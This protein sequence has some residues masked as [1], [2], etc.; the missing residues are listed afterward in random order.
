MSSVVLLFN[1][2][3]C[4]LVVDCGQPER[5]NNGDRQ[6]FSTTFESKAQY[7]CG[8]GYRLEG[9]SERTCQAN[10]QW[11]GSVP[12]CVLIDCGN[13]GDPDNG[14]VVL[15][16]GVTTL[17]AIAQYECSTGYQLS[18]NVRRSCQS[19][20]TWSLSEPACSCECCVLCVVL[21]VVCCVLFVVC[22]A[23]A[24]HTQCTEA[25]YAYMHTNE[26]CTPARFTLNIVVCQCVM[27]HDVT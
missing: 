25:Q 14:R 27:S 13:P 17:G 16:R 7:V 3:C 6:A 24:A 12:T 19:D 15:P 8:R 5:P 10:G 26:V 4:C 2:L 1:S 11:S 18:S 22:F 20:G 9:A 21:C 23:S